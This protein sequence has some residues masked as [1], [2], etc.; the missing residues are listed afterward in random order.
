MADENGQEASENGQAQRQ[1]ALHPT[2]EEVE[3]IA[4]D[5]RRVELKVDESS[6]TGESV[7]I[8][9]DARPLDEARAELLPDAPDADDAIQAQVR[10]AMESMITEVEKPAESYTL[11]E[12]FL[13]SVHPPPWSPALVERAKEAEAMPCS[14]LDV[15]TYMKEFEKARVAS[16][17]LHHTLLG[18]VKS[19]LARMQEQL[20]LFGE[21]ARR[22]QGMARMVSGKREANEARE[23]FERVVEEAK[24]ALRIQRAIRGALGRR[25]VRMFHELETRN[26]VLGASA[27]HIQRIVRG[28]FGREIARI[29]RERAAIARL[30]GGDRLLRRA[31]VHA[32]RRL[33]PPADR[34]RH[35]RLRHRR[36]APRAA[37]VRHDKNAECQAHQEG[38]QHAHERAHLH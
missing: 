29:K 30:Q 15:R 4:S 38:Q 19:A 6:L 25:F 17:N 10:E 14:Y 24:A 23:R 22:I 32:A 26:L 8:Q 35:L 3:T 1:V 18:L 2:D 27:T 9:K 28:M 33:L 16:N 36:I 34:A 37:L 12:L 20:D 5:D 11:S 31:R 7:A 13:R 21:M